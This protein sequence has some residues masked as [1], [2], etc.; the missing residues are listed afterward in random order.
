MGFDL[1]KKRVLEATDYVAGGVNSG[2]RVGL[3]PHPLVFASARGP[4]LLDI[5][6]NRYVDY[7]LGMGPMMLGHSPGA[8]IA[9]AR[10]QLD[11]SLLVAGQTETEYE[12]AEL[13][14]E[15]V[16]SAETVRFATSGTEA[17]QAALRVARAATQRSVVV[18]FEG[19]YHGW[20]DNVLWSVAPE[21]GLA[22]PR[23][24]PTPVAGSEGQMADPHVAVLPWNAI[25]LLRD[26]LTRGDVAAVIMEPIMFNNAGILPLPGYLEQVR[27]LCDVHGSLLIFDEVIT[28]FR[29]APGGAQ[30][31][32]GVLPDLT[33]LGKALANGFP[34]AAL[35]GRRRYMDLIADRR[36]LQGGTYNTQSVSMAATL[37]TL[38]EI[39]T[40]VPHQRIARIGGRLIEGLRGAFTEAGLEAQIIGFPAVFNVRFGAA[41]A[42]EYRDFLFADQALYADFAFALLRRGIRI[43]PRGTWF[44]SDTHEDLH[45]DETLYAVRGVLAEL[46]TTS[47]KGTT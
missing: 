36:V 2:F 16:P 7:F 21:A 34:V 15:M 41:D 39:R 10:A 11:R 6:G 1:S 17:V 43:L 12:A 47:S 20:L 3:L 26:R 29:V 45:I 23:T 18:K 35:A 5:D 13:L 25:G 28:G 14:V 46:S 42:Q 19:H 30:E 9:A 37:A 31:M 38:R 44:L 4:I 24:S 32:F 22:G 27:K 33:V 8:V 40:G